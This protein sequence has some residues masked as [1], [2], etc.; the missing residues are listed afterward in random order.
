MFAEK[1]SIT[2]A[3][4]YDT[5]NYLL[6]LFI[7]LLAY[8]P[9]SSFYFGMKNDAF[10]DN[11]P[12]KFF[13][14][15]AIHNG[16]SPLWNPYMNFG[17]PVYADMGVAFWNPITWLFA[18]IGYNAYTLTLEVLLY[19]FIAG[20]C[21]YRL[22][23]Y[24][25]LPDNVSVCMACMYMCSGF[26]TGSLQYINFLTAAAFLPAVLQGILRL[27]EIPSAS[28]SFLLSLAAYMVL[29]SGHPAIPV[30]G[31]YCFL[32]LIFILLWRKNY[33]AKEKW[34]VIKYMLFAGCIL[35]ML[36]LPAIYSYISIFPFYSRSYAGQDASMLY[37]G[38][39]F[40][41]WLSFI[42]PFF[43]SGTYHF[44]TDD[45]A[46]RNIY[47]GIVPFIL[48]ITS[49]RFRNKYSYGLMAM[50]FIS[51]ILSFGGTFKYHLFSHLPMLS[52]IRT[53]G[54][55]R[56]YAV[57]SFC[58]TAGFSLHALTGADNILFSETKKI[59]RLFFI[60]F[61]ASLSAVC[62]L[63]YKNISGEFALLSQD[64]S[65]VQK[66]KLFLGSSPYLMLVCNLVLVIITAYTA[67]MF[68]RKNKKQYSIP[69]IIT[70][71]V[72]NSIICLPVTG[73][74]QVTLHDIQQ[75]YNTS[76]EG[77]PVP[78]FIPVNKID[79]L[80]AKTTG[81]TGDITYYNKKIGTAR[82]TDYPSCFT[83]TVDYFSSSLP[84]TISSKPW[85]FLK[86]TLPGSN[87]IAVNAFSPAH[88]S[89]TAQADADDSLVLLQNYYKHWKV[90]VNKNEAP[91]T[92]AYLTF[93]SAAI[94]AGSNEIEFVY[95]D[96]WL[97][98]LVII[99]AA[100]LIFF[101]GLYFLKWHRAI[102]ILPK[103][104]Q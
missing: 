14:S 60:F 58:V 37:L 61:A 92:K 29:A 102:D 97:T 26:F 33:S 89:I 82:L 30:A 23:K 74:G 77:F 8:L 19:I 80:D 27:I 78:P 95:E 22:G 5:G 67:W 68:L 11:F 34:Q 15:E 16:A 3:Q 56:V 31:L 40:S 43:T 76:P 36:Y 52:F 47:T 7:A 13:I 59:T 99:S 6:I 86:K 50:A 85:L 72:V 83:G 24:L 100:S 2:K 17:F 57:L 66:I 44:F 9:L 28:G 18:A 87:S 79:T 48:L 53:N 41:S 45:V 46:M 81:L 90:F 96:K 20:I 88:I 73:V 98:V 49:F 64:G 51:L 65:A 71:L 70:D 104:N 1:R 32:P 62:I 69:L 39:G 12:D 101:T 63:L 55:F 21:T 42:L 54:E 38:F 35:L 103:P 4:G 25:K 84:D 94:H 75:V 93:M 91:I 10:S